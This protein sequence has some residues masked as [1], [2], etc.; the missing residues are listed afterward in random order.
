MEYETSISNQAKAFLVNVHNGLSSLIG[1]SVKDKTGK[2]PDGV[3]VATFAIRY[4]KVRYIIE[5]AEGETWYSNGNHL[6]IVSKDPA[7]DDRFRI[8]Q[9][10]YCLLGEIVGSMLGS[11]SRR[12]CGEWFEE[13]PFCGHLDKAL[14]YAVDC[15]WVTP[16]AGERAGSQMRYNM[17]RVT[18]RTI[19]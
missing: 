7:L 5:P 13:H 8:L 16:C 2:E 17:A 10:A 12:E 18:H 19:H 4:F 6:E 3:I 14:Q 15:G 11:F 1:L 9:L